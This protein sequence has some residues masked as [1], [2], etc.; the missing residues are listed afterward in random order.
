MSSPNFVAAARNEYNGTWVTNGITSVRCTCSSNRR[1][2][3]VLKSGTDTSTRF[4]ISRVLDRLSSKL[5]RNA[6]P[7][8]SPI[9]ASRSPSSS[10]RISTLSGPAIAVQSRRSFLYSRPVSM[11]SRRMPIFRGVSAG[12]ASCSTLKFANLFAVSARMVIL[13]YRA[14][15]AFF[16]ILSGVEWVI[17]LSGSDSYRWITWNRHLHIVKN[18]AVAFAVLHVRDVAH[19]VLRGHLA[20]NGGHR[21][22]NSRG[23]L[24]R[25]SARAD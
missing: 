19:D 17:S 14:S 20:G 4:V 7:P 21:A 5:R 25:V 1:W 22:K 24:R 2:R 23:D 18:L 11:S 10:S 8:I 15:T 13:S 16:E 9:F 6:S 12:S 3:A